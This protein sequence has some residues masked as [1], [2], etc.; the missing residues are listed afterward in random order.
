MKLSMSERYK[1][2]TCALN[3]NTFHN[4]FAGDS[5]FAP[6]WRTNILAKVV[7][8]ITDHIPEVRAIDLSNNKLLS[9]DALAPFAT[10]LDKL[11]I[12]FLKDNKITDLRGLEKLK[13]KSYYFISG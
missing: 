5:F 1:A 8:I 7:N 6:L 10:K 4:S 2:D 13:G 12:L 3:L 9:L 11:N